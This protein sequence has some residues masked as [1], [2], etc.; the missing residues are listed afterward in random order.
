[1]IVH[2]RFMNDELRL[3]TRTFE[4]HHGGSRRLGGNRGA[5]VASHQVQTQIEARG[6]TR[7]R[8]DI[9]V[10]DI[11]NVGINL[12]FRIAARQLASTAPVCRGTPAVENT[13]CGQYERAGANRRDACTSR[14]RAANGEPYVVG[15]RP[16]QIVDTWYDHS[17][18]MLHG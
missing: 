4:R 17:I 13:G 6:G 5:E 15:N 11:E 7:G 16:I 18:G 8:Q 10:V 14:E 1:M 3:P 12:Y 2:R 9:P